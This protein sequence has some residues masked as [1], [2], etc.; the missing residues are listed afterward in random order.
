MRALSYWVWQYYAEARGLPAT[1]VKP[2]NAMLV[3]CL[4]LILMISLSVDTIFRTLGF[5]H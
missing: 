3:V 2:H 5:G 4:V 1:S